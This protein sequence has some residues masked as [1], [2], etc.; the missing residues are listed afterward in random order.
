MVG[1]PAKARVIAVDPRS[2]V[3]ELRDSIFLL[4]LTAS[5]LGVYLA[6]GVAAVRIF[7]A[8]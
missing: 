6:L 2:P 4:V 8:R 5:S 1:H 3:R 7:A